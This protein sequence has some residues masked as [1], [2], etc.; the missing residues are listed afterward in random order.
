MLT[1]AL[2]L[3]LEPSHLGDQPLVRSPA[4]VVFVHLAVPPLGRG[5]CSCRG[6]SRT[7]WDGLPEWSPTGLIHNRD[8]ARI[9]DFEPLHHGPP[10]R[11]PP[12]FAWVFADN[13]RPVET[14]R[15]AFAR[16]FSTSS[17][18]DRTSSRWPRSSQSSAAASGRRARRRSHGAALRPGVLGAPHRPARS[19]R[20]GP[21][22]RRRLGSHAVQTARVMER[23]EPLVA[24]EPP[25]L[26][27]VPGDVNSTL[28]AALVAREARRSVAHIESGLRSFDRSMPEEINRIV[29]DEFA[30]LP[31]RALGRGGRE[32]AQRGHRARAHPPRREHDDRH[33]LPARAGVSGL[34]F[35]GAARAPIRQGSCSSRCIARRSWTAPPGVGARAAPSLS[36]AQ[37]PSSS[38]C[39]RARVARIAAPERYP[40][41]RFIAP[42][43]YLDSS[44]WRPT[45]RPF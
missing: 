3:H 35:V 37:C 14:L 24:V 43:G 22:P 30:D 18:R 20:A 21:P 19:S 41:I 10:F 40:D 32:P 13:R 23:L 15:S 36:A 9:F 25:D 7:C 44:H 4:P 34:Q 33:P 26:A 17:A 16:S 12:T 6:S 45:R 11:Q 2:K 29:A 27:F 5:S 8:L 28:A 42:L 39:T 38:R 1:V 31:V